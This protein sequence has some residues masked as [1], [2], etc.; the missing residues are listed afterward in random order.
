MSEEAAKY[1]TESDREKA[2]MIA[3][4]C[5][6]TGLLSVQSGFA[7]YSPKCDVHSNR[8]GTTRMHRLTAY[9]TKDEKTL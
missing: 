4:I 2:E 7:A 9:A 1:V 3:K 5:W 8:T 6:Y